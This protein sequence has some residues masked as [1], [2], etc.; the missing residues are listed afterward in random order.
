MKLVQALTQHPE[1]IAVGIICLALGLGGHLPRLA[2]F[3]QKAKVRVGIHQLFEIAPQPP[4]QGIP[5]A[6]F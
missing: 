1:A 6:K 4:L 2:N 3:G 5:I